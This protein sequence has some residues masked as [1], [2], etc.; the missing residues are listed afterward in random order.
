MFYNMAKIHPDLQTVMLP[1]EMMNKREKPIKIRIGKPILPKISKEY[2][3]PEELGEFLKNK[4]YMMKSYFDK[5]N[6]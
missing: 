4:V 6:V 5:R 3:T 2:E 1:S